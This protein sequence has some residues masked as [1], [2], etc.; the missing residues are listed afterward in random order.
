[1]WAAEESAAYQTGR[2]GAFSP[3]TLRGAGRTVILG[4]RTMTTPQETGRQSQ[5]DV[6]PKGSHSKN[7]TADIA[8]SSLKAI[9]RGTG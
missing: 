8:C 5:W 6:A 4:G 7:A 1:M 2:K 9:L 3:E